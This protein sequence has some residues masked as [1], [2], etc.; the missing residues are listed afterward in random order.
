MFRPCHARLRS[1][2]GFALCRNATNS[3]NWD[4]HDTRS[5]PREVQELPLHHSGNF[6]SPALSPSD[7]VPTHQATKGQ[8][9]KRVKGV[10]GGWGVGGVRGRRSQ[11]F[12]LWGSLYAV[13]M[14]SIAVCISIAFFQPRGVTWD[15]PLIHWTHCKLFA[16]VWDRSL[17]NLRVP[18]ARCL[19]HPHWLPF[20]VLALDS[21]SQAPLNQ[22]TVSTWVPHHSEET[23]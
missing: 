17:V 10:K 23:G 18:F 22:T 20:T 11:G 1:C 7:P 4:D 9:S 12:H 15:L 6:A 14:V 21:D 5:H 8:N 16:L 3:A 19:C 13:C 2:R